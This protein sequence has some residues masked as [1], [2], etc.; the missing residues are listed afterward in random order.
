MAKNYPRNKATFLAEKRKGSEWIAHMTKPTKQDEKLVYGSM[1][2]KSWQ[3]MHHQDFVLHHSIIFCLLIDSYN[4]RMGSARNASKWTE[5]NCIAIGTLDS[6]TVF[7]LYLSLSWST[8]SLTVVENDSKDI[9]KKVLM[10][11][12]FENLQKCLI[13]IFNIMEVKVLNAMQPLKMVELLFL[14]LA[15]METSKL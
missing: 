11:T 3:K 15:R 1:K 12:V 13:L 7:S 9:Y 2:K 4:N 8:A 5:I 14:L 6:K 10:V